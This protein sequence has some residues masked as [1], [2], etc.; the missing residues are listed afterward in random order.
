MTVPLFA[1][2]PATD[3]VLFAAMTGEMV[4]TTSVASQSSGDVQED[5]SLLAA[6]AAYF[7]NNADPQATQE[8]DNRL[9]AAIHAYNEQDAQAT[10]A[11]TE[12]TAQQV[13][14][15]AYLGND[16]PTPANANASCT[17]SNAATVSVITSLAA[18]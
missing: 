2:E 3:N 10:Q 9:L 7:G 8:P 15:R 16:D 4:V 1:D 6:Q 11:A 5:A 14:E 13:A 12:Q 17:S 18:Q